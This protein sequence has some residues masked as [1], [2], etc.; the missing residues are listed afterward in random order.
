MK[1]CR[2]LCF[3]YGCAMRI[4]VESHDPEPFAQL[5]A[6]HALCIGH[7][8]YPLEVYRVELTDDD[9][10]LVTYDLAGASLVTPSG[11]RV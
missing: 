6:V 11:V 5:G 3:G 7:D 2:A 9:R 10:T 8:V 4:T 1:E